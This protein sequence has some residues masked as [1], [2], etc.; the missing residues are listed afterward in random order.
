M[1]KI[2]PCGKCNGLVIPREGFSFEACFSEKY[3]VN[4]GW[5]APSADRKRFVYQRNLF[6]PS[7]D[8]SKN[9]QPGL[10][11]CSIGI[12]LCHFNPET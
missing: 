4:C 2:K 8:S 3:C 7:L 11:N 10:K 1:E 6:R 9:C 12:Y 5:R